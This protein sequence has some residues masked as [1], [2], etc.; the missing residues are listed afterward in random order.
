MEQTVRKPFNREVYDQTDALARSA[1]RAR[2]DSKGIHTISSETFGVDITSLHPIGHE[3]EV[4]LVWTGEWPDAWETVH[5]PERKGK[6]FNNGKWVF[7]WILRADCKEAWLIDSRKLQPGML[8]EVPN[9]E[10]SNG[11]YFYDVPVSMAQK[12]TL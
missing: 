4:K 7:F 5:I 11:E 2:L 9:K 12:I 6:L 3:V 1:V 10:M 8:K